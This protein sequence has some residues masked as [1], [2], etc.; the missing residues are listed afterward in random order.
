MDSPWGG[1]S[2][3][4]GHSREFS[5]WGHLVFHRPFLLASSLPYALMHVDKA[6]NREENTVLTYSFVP[7]QLSFFRHDEKLPK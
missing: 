3:S 5:F 7:L 6:S 1:S 2:P 4:Q